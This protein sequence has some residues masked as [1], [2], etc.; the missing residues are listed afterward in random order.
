MLKIQKND[1]FPPKRTNHSPTGLPPHL[2]G[3]AK[4]KPAHRKTFFIRAQLLVCDF[5]IHPAL[6]G[7]RIF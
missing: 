5:T 3:G 7:Q 4:V 2:N 1:T 6:T